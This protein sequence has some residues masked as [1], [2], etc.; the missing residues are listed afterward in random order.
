MFPSSST[1]GEAAPLFVGQE[2]VTGLKVAANETVSS[3]G[4]RTFLSTVW[5][6]LAQV[7][8]NVHYFNRRKIQRK[9]LR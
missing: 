7:Y 6:I 2:T 9:N 1:P 5:Q 3:A 8:R 4:N